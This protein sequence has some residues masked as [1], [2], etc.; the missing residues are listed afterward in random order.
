LYP[1]T[2]GHIK[3]IAAQGDVVFVERV[4]ECRSLDGQRDL[5]VPSVGVFRLRDGLILYWGDYFDPRVVLE[6]FIP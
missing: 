1:E 2:I 5:M 4:D 6:K 3:A